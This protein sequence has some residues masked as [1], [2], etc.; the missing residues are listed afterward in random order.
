MTTRIIRDKVLSIHG[1]EAH[2]EITLPDQEDVTIHEGTAVL[3]VEST[4]RNKV[5]TIKMRHGRPH[6][7]TCEACTRNPHRWRNAPCV[8]V[9][10]AE[11][12]L[13]IRP[14]QAV[15]FGAQLGAVLKV[16]GMSEGK[17]RHELR[18]R[19]RMV[20]GDLYAA[21]ALAAAHLAPRWGYQRT[22]SRAA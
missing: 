4:S 7:C 3:H 19:R 8:H 20:G 12:V 9:R 11:A 2:I 21:V 10:A 15:A 5:H 18:T 6:S 17:F 13:A 22:Y 16:V 14:A 1:E